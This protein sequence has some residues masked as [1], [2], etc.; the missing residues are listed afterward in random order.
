MCL[1]R[2]V[3]VAFPAVHDSGTPFGQLHP[4]QCKEQIS[5]AYAHAVVTAARC[6]LER[7][8]VDDQSVD[9]V[10]M[11]DA[12]HADY[13]DVEL[14]VQLKCTSSPDFVHGKYIAWPLEAKNYKKLT[15]PKRYKKSILVVM[16]VPNLIDDWVVQ[17]EDSL[18]LVKCA[19]W[20][21]MSGMP[22]TTNIDSKTVHLPRDNVFNVEQL[23][24]M[25]ERVG[26]GGQP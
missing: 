3:T 5:I 6:K 10:I 15:G 8:S 1:S 4:N 7:I 20:A 18:E 26:N 14:D 12:D 21:G 24:K 23:L 16:V 19:Y 13:C 11:Q 25:L 17:S 22:A 2:W 9:A